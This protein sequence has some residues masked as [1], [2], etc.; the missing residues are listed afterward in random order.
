MKDL[1][2]ESISI[3]NNGDSI[4]GIGEFSMKPGRPSGVS[5][6]QSPPEPAVG[7]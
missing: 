5:A 6:R 2:E 7:N 3:Q 1:I 4:C